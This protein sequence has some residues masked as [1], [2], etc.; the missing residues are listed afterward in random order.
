M[1]IQFY[2]TDA[3]TDDVQRMEAAYRDISAL[4]LPDHSFAVRG[5]IH[6]GCC[7][8]TWLLI[9]VENETAN[10]VEFLRRYLPRPEQVLRDVQC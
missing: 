10:V 7:V 3:G 4:L 2:I 5:F 9:V 8:R 6:N 1:K